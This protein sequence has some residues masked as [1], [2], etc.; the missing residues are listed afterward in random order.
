M[1]NILQNIFKDHYEEMLYTLHPRKSVIENVD[2]MINCGDPSFGGA[3]YGCSSCG[4][5][6]FV[7]FRCHSR[8]CP[9]CGNKYSIDRTTSMSF[10]IINVQHRHCVFTIDSE[11]RHFFLEDRKLLSLLFEAVQSVIMRLFHKD[12][13]AE[14]FTP[15]F[16]LVLHTFGRDLKWNPHIHCLISEGALAT[17]VYGVQKLILTTNFSVMHSVP[18]FL[19]LWRRNL[20]HPSKVLRPNATVITKKVFMFMQNLTNVIRK[21]SSNTLDA[22]LADR[23]SL[24]HALIITMV[25]MSLSTTID[26][27]MT[28]SSS[29]QFL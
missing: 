9:T 13:K 10:K 5:F 21:L 27:K 14:K 16:I 15:G 28:S 4:T 18:H 25:K 8:F 20:V 29:K 12:N 7:P 1:S 22:I 6:K 19:I 2:K 11:L 3:M 24:L 26:M 23:L 17:A